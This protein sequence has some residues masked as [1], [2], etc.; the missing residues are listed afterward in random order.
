M[1]AACVQRERGRAQREHL[2]PRNVHR[3]L[4]NLVQYCASRP[5]APMAPS[6]TRLLAPEE[7]VALYQIFSLLVRGCR[8]PTKARHAGSSRPSFIPPAVVTPATQSGALDGSANP[9]SGDVEDPHMPLP[10]EL[11]VWLYSPRGLFWLVS[12]ACSAAPAHRLLLWMAFDSPQARPAP[13]ASG[14][15]RRR[16]L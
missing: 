11:K 3:H 13:A 15:M 5:T 6:S 4:L 9:Y 16:R 7:G 1:S 8:P 14:A 2:M 10:T 12:A